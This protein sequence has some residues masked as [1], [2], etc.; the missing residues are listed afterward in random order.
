MLRLTVVGVNGQGPQP[1]WGSSR[2][3]SSSTVPQMVAASWSGKAGWAITW[4][5]MTRR[6]RTTNSRPRTA[7]GGRPQAGLEGV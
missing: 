1:T 6:L 2:V 3:G 4:R 7:A 5:R